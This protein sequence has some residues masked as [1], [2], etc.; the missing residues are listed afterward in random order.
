VPHFP[1]RQ[2]TEKRCK[3]DTAT[4][5]TSVDIEKPYYSKNRQEIC[6]ILQRLNVSVGLMVRIKNVYYKCENSM[7]I[8]VV[9]SE[10]FQNF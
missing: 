4:C 7:V 1:V 2:I 6:E 10:L 5:F 9:K 8:N 3:F